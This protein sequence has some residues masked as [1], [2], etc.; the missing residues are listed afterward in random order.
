MS[1][2]TKGFDGVTP[3]KVGEPNIVIGFNGNEKAVGALRELSDAILDELRNSKVGEIFK[4]FLKKHPEMLQE[5]YKNEN[6][7]WLTTDISLHTIVESVEELDKLPDVSVNTLG[8][9]VLDSSD[10]EEEFENSRIYNYKK[11]WQ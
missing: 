11:R 7:R 5:V 8:Y 10:F 6:C 1:T 2:I 3:V 9:E 4:E